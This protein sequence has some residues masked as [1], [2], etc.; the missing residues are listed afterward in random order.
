V[1]FLVNVGAERGD[2]RGEPARLKGDSDKNARIWFG[3][4]SRILLRRKRLLIPAI[5]APRA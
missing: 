1:V 2:A 3:D 5:F 4:S